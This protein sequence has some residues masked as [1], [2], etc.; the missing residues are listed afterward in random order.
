MEFKIIAVDAD[1]N[2][3][4]VTVVIDSK[5][6]DEDKEIL[7]QARKIERANKL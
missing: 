7:K 1:N 5:K 3:K 4:Q 6:I 2:K